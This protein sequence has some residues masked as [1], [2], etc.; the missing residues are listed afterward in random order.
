MNRTQMAMISISQ[1]ADAAEPQ[2]EATPGSASAPAARA[3]MQALSAALRRE[4]RRADLS[5]SEVARRADLSKS[6][7]SQLESGI[8]N[9]SLETLWALCTALGIPFGQ[10]FD[11]P[12]PRTQVI[13]AGSGA[14]V[15]AEQA[16]YRVLLLATCP[17]GARRDVYRVE[18]EPGSVRRSDPHAP[19]VVEH[20]VVCAGRALVGVAEEPVE[21]GPG[22]YIV[23]PGDVPHLFEALEPGTWAV[24]VSE[25]V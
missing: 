21:L 7:L 24:T 4:R 3:S 19:G 11:P 22:D 2:D 6:T 12:P 23:Y 17:P 9:P 25:H 18:A 5:L 10:L 20:V 8:G 13:R 16:D 14:A 15:A 1:A